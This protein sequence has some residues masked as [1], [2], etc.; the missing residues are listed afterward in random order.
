VSASPSAQ[1]SA[2]PAS[3]SPA[4]EASCGGNQLAGAITA[5]EGAAGSR[6][7]TVIVT[8]NSQDACRLAGPPGAALIDGSGTVLAASSG[9][10]GGAANLELP[11]GARAQLLIAVANWCNDPPRPPV[12]IGLTLPDGTRLVVEPA[13][14]GAFEP[15]PCNGPGQPASIE[16]QPEGWTAAN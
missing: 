5:W 6:I 2:P 14:G 11:A 3:A 7:G 9:P 10:V 1:P 12:S 15:P 13:A 16:V 4:G 8:N